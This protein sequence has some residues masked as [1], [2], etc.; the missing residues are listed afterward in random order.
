MGKSVFIRLAAP[1]VALLLAAACSS[2]K[3]A[4]FNAQPP[5]PDS[6]SANVAPMPQTSGDYLLQPGDKLS[7]NVLGADHLSGEFPVAGD[8]TVELPMIGQMP[9][10]GRNVNDIQNELVN[11]YSSTIPNPQVLVSVLN[12]GQ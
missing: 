8:G 1:A 3:S 5:M 4:D 11:R 12:A 6:G 10:A 2:N 9:A 7:V